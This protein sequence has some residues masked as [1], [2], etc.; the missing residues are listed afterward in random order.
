MKEIA[1][2]YPKAWELFEECFYNH[3][4]VGYILPKISP[5]TISLRCALFGY[6]VLE[7]FPK[8]GILVYNNCAFDKES[9]SYY[10][11]HRVSDA[12]HFLFVSENPEE[13]ID[14]AFEILESRL[15]NK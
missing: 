7:F 8:H 15:G 13:V 11:D 3:K 5:A 4:D 9:N 1:E 10:L 14:K 12:C 6:L 2:K